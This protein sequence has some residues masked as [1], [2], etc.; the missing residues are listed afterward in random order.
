LDIR[1]Y[2]NVA[3]A[4]FKV[5]VSGAVVGC[6]VVG[7]AVGCTSVGCLLTHPAK[8][9]PARIRIIAILNFILLSLFYFNLFITQLDFGS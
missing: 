4:P 7:C 3:P 5:M 2:G 6:T 8:S 1:G 9:T